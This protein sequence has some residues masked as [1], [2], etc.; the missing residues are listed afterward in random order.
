MSLMELCKYV[1]RPRSVD[2]KKK[3]GGN[4]IQDIFFLPYFELV[5]SRPGLDFIRK[6][7]REKMERCCQVGAK[8]K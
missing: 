2:E 4:K 3:K 5:F 1:L 8:K 6:I 7:I